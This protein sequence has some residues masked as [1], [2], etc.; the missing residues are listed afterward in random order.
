M[1]C[2]PSSRGSSRPRDRTW[3]SCESSAF[4]RRVLY[5]VRHSYVCLQSVQSL[6]RVRWGIA[7]ALTLLFLHCTLFGNKSGR[8]ISSVT[9][10]EKLLYFPVYTC[11]CAL[12][13]SRVRLSAASQ[14]VARQ[15][16]LSM[17]F[18]RQEHWS[19]LPFP[20]PGDLPDPGIEPAALVSPALAGGFIMTAP[21]GQP[22]YPHSSKE[23][24]RQRRIKCSPR[25]TKHTFMVEFFGFS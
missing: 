22:R 19:G 13:L 9:A 24:R 1:G 21:P 17:G 25:N 6:R 23:E 18:P 2:L 12:V 15:A 16:S 5:H 8:R 14:M 3:A 4:G 11:M 7:A 10:G 20:P